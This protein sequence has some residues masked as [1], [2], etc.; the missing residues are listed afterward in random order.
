MHERFPPH[1]MDNLAAIIAA[2]RRLGWPEPRLRWQGGNVAGWEI[3]VPGRDIPIVVSS[4][5]G[6]CHNAPDAESLHTFQQADVVEFT[7]HCVL[8]RGGTCTE[9]VL[10]DGT[11][12]LT[13]TIPC[14]ADASQESITP[15]S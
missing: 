7:R 5:G 3:T 14:T 12:S 8:N 4:P 2:C 10:P 13:I 9:E 15:P 11:I 6:I 1:R